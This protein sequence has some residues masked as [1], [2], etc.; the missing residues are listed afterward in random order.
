M[1]HFDLKTT[2][3]FKGDEMVI[4]NFVD[5]HLCVGAVF[6]VDIFKIKN[7]TIIG[8]Q[9]THNGN[10]NCN[11]ITNNMEVIFLGQNSNSNQSSTVTSRDDATSSRFSHKY[12]SCKTLQRKL[13]LKVERAKKNY[14][15]Q[16]GSEVTQVII[17]SMGFIWKKNNKLNCI[18]TLVI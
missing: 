14:S 3:G 12:T 7:S 6:F 15:K 1:H 13:E 9:T 8:L 4:W 5:F 2:N 16:N 10:G 11:D 17:K 18:F